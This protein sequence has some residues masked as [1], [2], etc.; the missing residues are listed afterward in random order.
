[1]RKQLCVFGGRNSREGRGR[2][3]VKAFVMILLQVTAES[4]MMVTGKSTVGQSCRGAHG[5]SNT[6]K[7][8]L[9]TK[10]FIIPNIKKLQKHLLH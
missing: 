10:V 3:R 6:V 8:G 5:E 9:Q 1:M 2:I 7:Q 4:E